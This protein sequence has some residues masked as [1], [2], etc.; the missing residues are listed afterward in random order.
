M[1]IIIMIK[2]ILLS[3]TINEY[4]NKK[5]CVPKAVFKISLV[6]F[7]FCSGAEKTYV[8]NICFAYLFK[9]SFSCNVLSLP[10]D[11]SEPPP[12]SLPFFK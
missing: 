6:S 1:K 2:E 10:M 12:T 7:V 4:L 11:L 5:T 9:D 3:K 8:I